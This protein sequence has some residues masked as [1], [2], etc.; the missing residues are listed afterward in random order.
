MSLET[1][2]KSALKRYGDE[3]IL[4]KEYAGVFYSAR[5]GKSTIHV[6]V[7]DFAAVKFFQLPRTYHGVKVK[8]AMGS[9]A[10]RL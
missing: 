9:E 8:Y 5:S 1:K 4:N 6:E 3:Y 2:I 10:L 7:V